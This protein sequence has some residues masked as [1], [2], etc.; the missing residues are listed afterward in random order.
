MS[1]SSD[2]FFPDMSDEFFLLNIPLND[3][4]RVREESLGSR[5]FGEVGVADELD[6]SESDDAERSS[7][8]GFDVE[9]DKALSEADP[10]RFFSIL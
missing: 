7:L 2:V 3:I 5:L 6:A 4:L 1:C 8:D 10:L 9:S